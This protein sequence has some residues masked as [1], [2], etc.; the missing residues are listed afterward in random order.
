MRHLKVKTK[1]LALLAATLVFLAAV[2]ITGYQTTDRIAAKA[3]LM[4]NQNMLASMDINQVI[5]DNR[6]I[7]SAIMEL[8]LTKDQ[9]R[10]DELKNSI[11]ERIT[12]N[13]KLYAHLNTITLTSTSADLYNQYKSN[14]NTYQSLLEQVQSLALQNNNTEAY[15]LFTAKVEPIRQAMN[16][17]TRSLN[18]QLT[19][20]AAATSE[21]IDSSASSSKIILIS[22]IAA[23]ILLSLL[24]GFMISQMITRP[25]AQLQQL[26]SRA[27]DGDLTVAGD[28]DSRDEIGMVTSSFN[29]MIG[30]VKA[31]IR[32]VD[33][34]A[35]TL[36]ASSEELTASAEQTAQAAEHI[37][38][39]TNEMSTGIESQVESVNQVNQSVSSMYEKMGL[40]STNSQEIN[41]LTEQ[42]TS[43]AHN[44]L[45]EVNEITRLIKGLSID[46][47]QNLRVM[48]Q[49][50]TTS[51]QIGLASSSI[52]QIAQQTNLL[53][54][55]A[56]I[57]AAR[58]GEAGRGFA[59]VA[60]EIRKLA[61]GAADSSKEISDMVQSI[62][63][64][65][66]AAVEQVNQSSSSIQASVQSSLRVNTAFE[67]IRE[68]VDATS[69]K[70]GISSE[71]IQEVARQSE[72]IAE[73]ME[74]VSAITE[75]SSAGIQQTGAASEEQLSTMEEVSGSA[76]YLSEL[77]EN[78]QH[79]LARFKI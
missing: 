72:K 9:Q 22:V 42:M 7:E 21:Q 56:S 10:N 66:R 47:E 26:M 16:A 12:S 60:E 31:I 76:R 13:E 11:Q 77:A 55:N 48:T 33:E 59:V 52:Q 19:Q 24:F 4:Y 67:A 43:A 64:S 71:M 40:V 54:L 58:A 78:L 74:H 70:I 37:A 34:S 51:D 35:L 18:S 6:T 45:Q 46:M 63:D 2:G 44:G 29:S 23:G 68:S 65:S 36:S 14:L 3:Q 15:S 27:G 41:K 38:V 17:A 28:Y 1:I 57:E 62:Q 32:Q 5:I 75:Q 39:A 20:E 30:N 73:A 25:L 53:A 61:T 8:M 69:G 79:A 50:N 49:L